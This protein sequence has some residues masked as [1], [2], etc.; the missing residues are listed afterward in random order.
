MQKN[1]DQNNVAQVSVKT[2]LIEPS[3]RSGPARWGVWRMFD[4]IAPR[5]DLL[6]RLLSFRQD[7]RW[8]KKLADFLPEGRQV[9]LV[10]L[11]TGTGDVVITLCRR[12]PAVIR[13]TGFDLAVEMLAIGREKIKRAGLQDRA[14]LLEGDALKVPL[15]DESADVVTIAFGIRNV[16]EPLKG[17]QEMYRLLRPGGIALVLEFS[18]PANRLL[19]T[20]YLFYFRHM[21]PWIG[22]LLSGDGYAYRYLN[23]TVETFP[24]GEAFACLMEAAGFQNVRWKPLTLGVATIYRGT[25]P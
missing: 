24:Y 4:R 21:L 16:E 10:D 1:V 3:L 11:A 22:G 15:P 20:L 25:K 8:R 9:H 6:N 13:A 2:I 12:C 14:R 19:K 23:Q 18:L 17:L 5:Y 7:V